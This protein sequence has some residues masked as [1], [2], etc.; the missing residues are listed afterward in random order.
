MG[1][2]WSVGGRHG[3][4]GKVYSE[5]PKGQDLEQGGS[6]WRPISHH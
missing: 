2:P 3:E 1:V 4:E 5:E 6:Y